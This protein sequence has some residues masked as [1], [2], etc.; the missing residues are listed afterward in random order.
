M[1]TKKEKL[2][3]DHVLGRCGNNTGEE[4]NFYMIS[5]YC[6]EFGTVIDL[7]EKGYLNIIGG[8]EQ[9]IKT[10]KATEKGKRAMQWKPKPK[11]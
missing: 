6:S 5:V 7:V 10:F 11:K 9:H 8:N 2:V 4:K 3:M 1:L